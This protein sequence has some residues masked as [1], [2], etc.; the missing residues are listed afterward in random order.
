MPRRLRP[1]PARM[2]SSRR[3]PFW[4][5]LQT[6]DA[7]PVLREFDVARLGVAPERPLPGRRPAAPRQRRGEDRAFLSGG[8]EVQDVGSQLILATAGAEPGG[9]WL[10]ACAGA[11]GKTLQLA[12]LLGP[13]AASRPATPAGRPQRALGQGCPGRPWRAPA[14]RRSRRIPR[15][16]STACLS[17]PRARAS[18]TWRR[19]PAPQVGHEGRKAFSAAADLQLRLLEENAPRIKKGGL[20]IYATCS[21]CRT[22]NEQV[23][24]EFLRSH[25]G[26]EPES[27]GRTLLPQAHDGDGFFVAT[28][29]RPL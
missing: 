20:L 17:M 26:F 8:V 1:S 2:R 9:H 14:G 13:R 12:A 25:A 11:G 23:A 15:T 22:E 16:A 4:L 28:F 3:P 6:D 21:L 24:A 5:R 19:A 10:D 29:R 27:P 18:G 7:A